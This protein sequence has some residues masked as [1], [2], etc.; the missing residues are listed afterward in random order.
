MGLIITE[1]QS[2]LLHI[3]HKN[4]KSTF[5]RMVRMRRK[6]EQEPYRIAL[7]ALQDDNLVKV[8]QGPRGGCI[9]SLTENGKRAVENMRPA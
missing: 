6:T 4:G 1:R 2:N 5:S 7:N 9:Y 8:K 3:L